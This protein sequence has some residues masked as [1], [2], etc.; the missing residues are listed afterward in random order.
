MVDDVAVAV[1]LA[2]HPVCD[3]EHDAELAAAMMVTCHDCGREIAISRWDAHKRA[4]APARNGFRATITRAGGVPTVWARWA[5]SKEEHEPQSVEGVKLVPCE[6]CGR[7][8]SV[9]RLAVHRQICAQ[10]LSAFRASVAALD[11]LDRQ[12]GW[13]KEQEQARRAE[14]SAAPDRDPTVGSITSSPPTLSDGCSDPQLMA[15]EHCG[16]SFSADRITVHA[17]ICAQARHAFRTSVAVLDRIQAQESRGASSNL[18]PSA[19]ASTCS[20]APHVAVG[21]Q[22]DGSPVTVQDSRTMEVGEPIDVSVDGG[23]LVRCQHCERMFDEARLKVHER[24][25]ARRLPGWRS[26][27]AALDTADHEAEVTSRYRQRAEAAELAL[28]E[29][30]ASFGQEL[31]AIRSELSVALRKAELAEA[32]AKSMEASYDVVAEA[33]DKSHAKEQEQRKRAEEAES[34]LEIVSKRAE[35]AEAAAK[36]MEASYDVLAE[37]LAKSEAKVAAA[38]AAP[39]E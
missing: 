19:T 24:I 16:R 26:T 15:C 28:E 10:T 39:A 37:A 34:A 35:L 13:A 27:V 33:L 23:A 36:S 18:D 22:S 8:F 38:G 4:C 1:R 31:E 20:S 9:A 12:D 17:Q 25:C 29:R 5:E 2:L 3:S 11:S 21:V 7:S 6:H 32:A 14:G 30:R